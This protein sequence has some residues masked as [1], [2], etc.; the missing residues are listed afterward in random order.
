MEPYTTA[1]LTYFNRS[2]KVK[3]KFY[4]CFRNYFVYLENNFSTIEI[5]IR[6]NNSNFIVLCQKDDLQF[7][8]VGVNADAEVA[9]IEMIWYL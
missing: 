4:D 3:I 5:V 9:L 7:T 2:S 8:F 6:G 1:I